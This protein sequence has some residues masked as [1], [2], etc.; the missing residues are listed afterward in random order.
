MAFSISFFTVLFLFGAVAFFMRSR[1]RV[2]SRH[3]EGPESV[4]NVYD[5]WT[6]NHWL[7][8]YWG[9]HLH[10]GYY[11]NPPVKKDF[12]AAK[13]DYIDKLIKWGIAN[14]APALMKRLEQPD[15]TKETK[16]VKILDLG[17]GIGGSSRHMAKRWSKSA[18]VTG[19]T[20]SRAQA[21]RATLLAQ[22]QEINNVEFFEC[23]ALNMSFSDASF[24]IVW[25][26]ESE[27]HMPDKN[28]FIHEIVRVLKRGGI[29]VVTAWNVRD[30]SNVP[31]SKFEKNHIQLL[32]DEWCHTSFSSAQEFIE[33]FKQNGLVEVIFDDWTSPTLPS[34]RHAVFVALRDPR[35]LALTFPQQFWH[36]TRN[37]YTI[38]QF[39]RAFRSGLCQYGV[40]HGKK[41]G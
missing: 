13:V 2:P 41:A 19:V 18:F 1:L 4:S 40:I 21:K 36:Q 22:A 39:D 32:V 23:D 29:L 20:I 27:M 34:W 7:E 14:P 30:T 8:F 17:C 6:N 15:R 28:Q 33:L 26:V 12:I 31:L 24:D 11:G 5:D 38:L 35:G 10:A 37:A 16:R 25:A 3:Y 9:E